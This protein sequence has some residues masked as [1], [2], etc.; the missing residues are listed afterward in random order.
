MINAHSIEK[1][2]VIK[3]IFILVD[4]PQLGIIKAGYTVLSL[5]SCTP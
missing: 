3:G 5:L 2:W 1:L 4:Y